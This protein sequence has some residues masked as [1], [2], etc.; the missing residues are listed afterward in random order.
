[1]S[2]D[3]T[4]VGGQD[5]SRV[6]GN[7]PYEVSYFAQK[8]GISAEQARELIGKHGNDRETLDR[9]AEKLKS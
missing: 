7:E 3:K 5:R 2:D 1:M 6:A 4:K 8:H 9:E